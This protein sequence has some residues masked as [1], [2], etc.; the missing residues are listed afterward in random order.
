MISAHGPALAAGDVNGDGLDDIYI[1]GS[2]GVA[3]RL[4]I[5]QKNGSFV[6][7][8][9]GQPWEADKAFDDWSAVF[10][11]ANGDGKPDL[12]VASCS[13]SQANGSPLL[14]DRLYINQG[15]GRFARSSN[16]LPPM[17]TSK[18][19]V[20]VGDYNGDGRPDLF[21]GGRLMPRKWPYPTRSYIL[22]NDGGGRFTDV[23]EQVAPMLVNPG[24]MITDATWVD[25]DGDGQLDLVTVGEWMPIQFLKNEVNRFSDVTSSTGL[26]SDRGWWFSIA[27]GDFDGDG[28]PDIVAG[29]LGLNHTYA[30]SKDTTLEVYANT[31]TGNQTTDIVLA[32]RING[33]SYSLAGMSPLGREVYTTG[34]RFP[35]FGSYAA[36]TLNQLFGQEQLKQSLHYDVDT[37]ASVL[38]HNDG[39]GKFTMT[40]LPNAAQISP[41]K[42]IVARD[43]DGDG[44]LDLV[45]KMLRFRQATCAA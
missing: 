24:G 18:G 32:D 8:T 23:T 35:T 9:Q 15:G 4:F 13:Y 2:P 21:V 7:S 11:D 10:F 33:T 17:L 34:I 5:Q 27:S 28:R 3:G 1:G 22:R 43:I 25:F 36:A 31:F 26:S 29:N 38:L 30:T 42:G 40:K 41:I 12:Y 16:A 20:R 6:E 45:L 19:V 39:G 14:Q 37:F 44:H